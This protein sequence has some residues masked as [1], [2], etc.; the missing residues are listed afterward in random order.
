[1]KEKIET[2]IYKKLSEGFDF[3]FLLIVNLKLNTKNI[4]YL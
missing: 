1:M 3:V 2:E 4:I